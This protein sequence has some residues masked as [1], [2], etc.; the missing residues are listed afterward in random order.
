MSSSSTKASITRTGFSSSIQ[1][2]SRSGNN[3]LCER[4]APSMNRLIGYLDDQ[5]RRTYYRSIGRGRGAFSHRL[6][7]NRTV[8][9][10]ALFPR[11]RTFKPDHLPPLGLVRILIRQSVCGG[12]VAGTTRTQ[13]KT[14]IPLL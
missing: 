7:H 1:S 9:P 13:G 4:A 8:V 10:C 2:S 5:S 3:R 6:G 14:D 12:A 11:L